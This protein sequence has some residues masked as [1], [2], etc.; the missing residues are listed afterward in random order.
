VQV[1]RKSQLR[2]DSG[3]QENAAPETQPVTE[4]FPAARIAASPSVRGVPSRA[5]AV[6][7][8]K[9]FAFISTALYCIEIVDRKP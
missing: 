8:M 3:G 2:C 7:G 5:I 1:R 6:A 4:Q 9:M